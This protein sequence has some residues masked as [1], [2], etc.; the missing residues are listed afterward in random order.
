MGVDENKQFVTDIYAK[1]GGMVSRFI[2]SQMC[3]PTNERVEDCMHDV[4][5]VLCQKIDMVRTFDNIPAWLLEVSA[6]QVRAINAKYFKRT[7]RCIQIGEESGLEDIVGDEDVALESYCAFTPDFLRAEE[8]RDILFRDMSESE[9]T[10]YEQRYIQNLPIRQLAE[11]LGVSE[12]AVR[13]RLSR[14]TEKLRNIA[15]R[16]F[17]SKDFSGDGCKDKS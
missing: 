2:R 14:L 16:S 3:F 15:R 10:F 13:T 17:S 5:I 1:Y 4:F 12:G 9:R 7:T 8:V 11:N 6:R